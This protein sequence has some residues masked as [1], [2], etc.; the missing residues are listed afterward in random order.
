[1]F[2]QF[3]AGARDAVTSALNEATL[4]G[5]RRI[6][7]QHLLLG[8][9]HEPG[10]VR[11]LGIDL[12][13]ARAALDALDRSALAAI[14]IDI[15][16]IERPPIPASRKRTPFTSGARAVVPRALAETRKAGS[17]RITPEHLLLALL[18]CAQPD[19][20]AELMAQLGIDRAAVRERIR[21]GA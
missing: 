19:P 14:G 8:V 2:E 15:Q 21:T 10:S 1:M 13:T 9:L 20:A 17:R 6:G 12:K 7:T 3:A 16:G 18:D 5:D 11:A 4:R